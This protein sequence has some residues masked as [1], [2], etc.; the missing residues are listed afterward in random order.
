MKVRLCTAGLLLLIGCGSD[1]E[2]GPDAPSSGS[3]VRM[4][5]SDMR[6]ETYLGFEGGLYPGGSTTPPAE[7]AAEGLARGRAIRPLDGD[8]RPQAQGR[9]ALISIGMSNTTQE[10]CSEAGGPPCDAWTFMGQAA[11]D[12]TVND[13]ALVLVNGAFSGKTA[14]AWDQPGDPDYDRIRDTRL[15]ALGLTE[16][17]VV[18]AW[19]KVA[20]AR[21]TASLPQESADAYHLVVQT[22]NIVRAL[23]ARYPSL[24][25]VFFSSRIYAGYASSDLNPEPYAYES[26]LAMKWVI[27][28]Q[29]EQVRTGRVDPRAGDLD[30]RRGAPWL[31][32]G[33]YLWADGT[34]PRADGLTWVT[35]DFQGDGTHPARSGEQKVGRLLLEFFKQSPATR[36]WFVLG[37]TCG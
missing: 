8:G 37:A 15:R 20:N 5:L 22:G 28:A 21:P 13:R 18:A 19:V 36:C 16:A 6:R 33:P 30:Y 9:Y 26:G 2:P 11:A 1:P 32:W 23:K 24:Q 17:Q 3:A 25:Q 7:H 29:I 35:S 4:P 10:F 34:S 31:A 14:D 27:A 12:A